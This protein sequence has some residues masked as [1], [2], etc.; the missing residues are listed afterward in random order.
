MEEY[1]RSTNSVLHGLAITILVLSCLII[2]TAIIFFVLRNKKIIS[3]NNPVKVIYILGFIL[4]IICI[5][6]GIVYLVKREKLEET[7]EIY[8]KYVDKECFSEAPIKNASKT[9]SGYASDVESRFSFYA[10]YFFI[11]ALV[12]MLLGLALAIWRKGS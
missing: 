3:N 5:T 10:L 11:S 4:L 12:I 9:I 2:L 6:L 1:A 7:S 8:K